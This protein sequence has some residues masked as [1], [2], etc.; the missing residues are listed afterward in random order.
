MKNSAVMVNALKTCDKGKIQNIIFS[1]K[2][3]KLE[4]VKENVVMGEEGGGGDQAGRGEGGHRDA[5][6]V[7]VCGYE[8]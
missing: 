3:I 1:G 8:R 7:V 6:F 5:I 2:R 4:C